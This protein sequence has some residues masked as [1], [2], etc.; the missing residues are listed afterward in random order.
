M[1]PMIYAEIDLSIDIPDDQTQLDRSIFSLV[2]G[3]SLTTGNLTGT[4]NVE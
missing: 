2:H 4:L 3:T 1:I